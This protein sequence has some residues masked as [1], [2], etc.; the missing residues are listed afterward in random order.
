MILLYM[1]LLTRDATM[2]IKKIFN[3]FWTKFVSSSSGSIAEIYQPTI[4]PMPPVKTYSHRIDG[5]GT[6]NHAEVCVYALINQKAIQG[7]KAIENCPGVYIET[8][9]RCRLWAPK[10][11][12]TMKGN[13]RYD[14]RREN[15]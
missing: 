1:K 8:T 11:P 3:S 15:E 13:Q 7:I 9:I 10:S 5:C 2:S 12:N 6:C 14:K 4:P